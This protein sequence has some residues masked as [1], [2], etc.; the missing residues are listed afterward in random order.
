MSASPW[1]RAAAGAGASWRPR[2][3]RR[4]SLRHAR[5]RGQALV[6][7]VII[8]PLAIVLIGAAIDLG[9]L[10]FAYVAV[11]NAAKEG[12]W[13]GAQV[14]R[15]DV[16]KTGCV[17]PNTVDWHVRAEL[18]SV[19]PLAITA[20]CLDG[21]SPVSVNACGENDAYQVQVSHRFQ[22]LTPLLSHVL[23]QQLTLSSTATTVV[24]NQ[25]FDPDATPFPVPTPTPAPTATPTPA[26]TATATPAPTA[27]PAC[28]TVPDLRGKTF[29]AARA[30]WNSLFTGGFSPANG[31]NNKIV[32]TQ[33]TSPAS[34]PGNCIA[35]TAS[36][37]VSDK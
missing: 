9:R 28:V 14:P 24:L 30:Q 16:A 33:T 6:E 7:L 34:A 11:E 29:S 23:G 31:Q 8:L 3:R 10:F 17:D 5:S 15:C 26:P 13:F 25:S 22:L 19:P 2:R 37:T 32:L 36:V 20:Q 12:A 35:A 4:P 27:T 18:T 1:P 21:G